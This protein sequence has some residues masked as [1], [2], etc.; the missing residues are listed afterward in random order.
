LGS[1]TEEDMVGIVENTKTAAAISMPII[2][3]GALFGLP[4]QLIA[5]YKP[6]DKPLIAVELFNW[7]PFIL[8]P[9]D[10]RVFINRVL[11]YCKAHCNT[12]IYDGSNA[13]FYRSYQ[14]ETPAMVFI[15][16]DHS[17]EGVKFDIDWA[18]K[19]GVPIISGHDYTALHPGVKRAVDEAFCDDIN[20]KGNRVDAF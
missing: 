13:D 19:K 12:C 4:T 11:S 8:S 10:H 9:S 14:C 5:T 2:E 18:V 7:N 17:Y 20:H 16:A 1:T 6:A 3:I 15:D